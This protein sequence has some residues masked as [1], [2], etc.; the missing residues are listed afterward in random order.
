MIIQ[1]KRV[2]IA[3]QLMPAQ[4]EIKDGK[5][6][7][8]YKYGEKPVDVDYGKERILPGFYDIHTHGY[9]GYDTSNGEPEGLKAWC[10]YL[11]SEG[12]CGFLP[13]TLTQS[14]DVLV[15]SVTQVKDVKNEN[16]D[17]AE[18]MGIHFEGPYLNVNKKG[19][20]PEEY[21]VKPSIEEF[22]EYQEACDNMIRIITLAPEQDENFEL[23]K[24]CAATGVRVSIGHT[25]ADYET[26]VLA[27]ANGAAGFTHTYNGMTAFNHRKNGV[28]GASLRCHDNYSEVICDGNHSTLMALNMFFREKLN[29]GIMVTD[30]LMCKGFP[31]GSKFNFGGQ[32]IEIYPDGSAHLTIGTKS[33]AGGGLRINQ[34]LRI[35]VE[36]AMVPFEDA[37]MSVSI[38]PIRYLGLD[39]HKGKIQTG[40]DADIVVLK[41]DYS[42]AQTYCRGIAQLSGVVQ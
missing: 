36:E 3:S 26:A 25:E 20:Q 19:A 12:V 8:I 42:V 29:H 17:G 2:F 27:L 14:H 15:K 24:Y 28:I 37:L 33:L 23:T 22:K 18:I 13:T 39:D 31:V 11:P 9:H 32:E 1:S 38:N 16:P 7:G 4:V 30:S 5:I 41:D 40:F 35:L 34:G 10:K 21:I 6:A